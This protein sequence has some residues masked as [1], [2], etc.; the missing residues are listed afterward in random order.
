MTFKRHAVLGK[1]EETYTQ[2]PVT[3]AKGILSMP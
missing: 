3:A 1:G 2:Q